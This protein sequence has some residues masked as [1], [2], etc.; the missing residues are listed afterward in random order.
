M[1]ALKSVLNGTNEQLISGEMT[2]LARDFQ[3]MNSVHRQLCIFY[4][5]TAFNRK[6]VNPEH[7]LPHAIS[8][9]RSTEGLVL[10]IICLRNGVSPNIYLQIPHGGK[11]HLMVYTVT[12]LKDKPSFCN[13]ACTCLRLLGSSVNMS[14]YDTNVFGQDGQVDE[15]NIDLGVIETITAGSGLAV[16]LRQPQIPVR[17]PIPE[18]TVREWLNKSGFSM[19]AESPEHIMSKYDADSKIVIGTMCDLVEYAY[20]LNVQPSVSNIKGQELPQK[21]PNIDHIILC[22][23]PNVM[24]KYAH[25]YGTRGRS[26]VRGQPYGLEAC[27]NGA[28]AAFFESFIQN[29]VAANY[30]TVN[31]LVLALADAFRDND[32]VLVDEYSLMFRNI[33]DYGAIIDK[34]Q[35]AVISTISSDLA[36]ATLQIY[37]KPAWYKSC[38]GINRSQ[39]RQIPDSLRRLAVSLGIDVTASSETICNMFSSYDLNSAESLKNAAIVRQKARIGATVSTVSSFIEGTVPPVVCRNTTALGNDPMDYADA[40][41]AFYKDDKDQLWCYTSDMFPQ[42][43]K[44]KTN[45]TIQTRLPDTF[46]IQMEE[47]LRILKQ[48]GVDSAPPISFSDALDS[49][50]LPDKIDDK[51]SQSVL[52]T[53]NRAFEAEGISV[54]RVR[55]LSAEEMNTILNTV[56]M[57]QNDLDRLTDEH[58]YITFAQALYITTRKNPKTAQV[59]IT[60]LRLELQPAASIA[61]GYVPGQVLVPV[62]SVTAQMPY[63]QIIQPNLIQ[64]YSSAPISSQQSLAPP[65][66]IQSSSPTQQYVQSPTQQ[67][68]QSPTQQYVQSPTQ[69]YFAG[70]QSPQQLGPQSPQ[71]FTPQQQL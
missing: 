15:S 18:G 31:R 61:A 71:R 46:I 41:M 29:G 45:P 50:K 62:S 60:N 65:Q 40:T 34:A 26:Y 11:G 63:K 4:M 30:F 16:G 2:Q 22:R 3:S 56:D 28:Y 36:N 21:H 42:L 13:I 52:S 64:V 43:I 33:I 7:F 69:Q 19:F 51:D 39:D 35:I 25:I 59:F 17:Q 1:Q 37:S 10:A 12:A 70:V 23:P 55:L 14:A 68:V 53:I 49:L 24:S 54:E 47:Q 67:Y 6:I 9:A 5:I 58:R 20:P 57:H 8:E 48:M 38:M 66:V 44:N 27:I 32:Q